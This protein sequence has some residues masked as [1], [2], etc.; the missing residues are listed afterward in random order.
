MVH[1]KERKMIRLPR[2]ATAVTIL[3]LGFACATA[4]AAQVTILAPEQHGV[5][6]DNEGNLA[7]DVRVEPPIDPKE[8][9]SIRIVLDG[10]PAAP[11]ASGTSFALQGVE[12]GEHWLQ[13]LLIDRKG[14]TLS[15]SDTVYFTMWQASVN[16]PARKNQ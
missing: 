1:G 5:V 12:R 9:T 11:D 3:L 8:G 16:S 15:V 2:Y 13:A 10:K 14:K 4:G 7:V 6:H